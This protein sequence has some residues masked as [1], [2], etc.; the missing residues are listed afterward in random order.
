MSI[1][2]FVFVAC[3]YNMSDKSE[4]KLYK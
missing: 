3:N 2:Q 1:K 4:G